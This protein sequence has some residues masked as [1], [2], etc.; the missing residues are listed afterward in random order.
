MLRLGTNVAVLA[1]CVDTFISISSTTKST[2][3]PQAGR[4]PHLNT[5]FPQK[6][7]G[8]SST[9]AGLTSPITPFSQ[10]ALPSKS[11]LSRPEPSST[12]LAFPTGEDIDAEAPAELR[13]VL[14]RGVQR[15]LQAVIDRL[16]ERCFQQQRYRQVI[17]IAVEAKNLNIL[18]MAI[19]RAA[20][21][22]KKQG[23][24]SSK[25]GEELMDYVLGICMNIVQERAF[26]NEVC[27]G[28]KHMFCRAVTKQLTHIHI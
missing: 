11:L 13:L 27:D 8:A 20:E 14:Q 7:G 18:R 22:E 25:L 9:S 3:S 6:S 10:S 28:A 19:V 24:D 15:Q 17:G 5:S 4:S 21:D 16:F 2:Q 23:L 26:R 1:K 12:E